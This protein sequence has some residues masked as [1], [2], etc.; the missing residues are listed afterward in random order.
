MYPLIDD[1]RLEALPLPVAQLVRGREDA[2]IPPDIGARPE[3]EGAGLGARVLLGAHEVVE[4][5]VLGLQLGRGARVQ[6]LVEVAHA[7]SAA[8]AAIE[9]LP[10]VLP[11]LAA[12]HL[13]VQLRDAEAVIHR[14]ARTRHGRSRVDQAAQLG[15][16][17]HEAIHGPH[18]HRPGDDTQLTVA[19]EV[20][21]QRLGALGIVPEAQEVVAL[22]PLQVLHRHGRHPPAREVKDQPPLGHGSWRELLVHEEDLDEAYLEVQLKPSF[23]I[24]LPKAMPTCTRCIQLGIVEE[25]V[26]EIVTIIEVIA[27]QISTY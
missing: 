2:V 25:V 23:R 7:P 14:I 6:R 22:G 15:V 19:A 12:H 10:I 3:A 18:A 17:R 27:K 16:G 8:E 5:I 13:V 20:E 9:A 24:Q 1:L 4:G 11:K 21:V 26:F